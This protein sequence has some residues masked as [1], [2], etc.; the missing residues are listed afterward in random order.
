MIKNLPGTSYPINEKFTSAFSILRPALAATGGFT[1]SQVKELT[2]LE[3][4]TIQNWVK[5]GWVPSPEEKKYKELHI[6]R[7]LI[8]N[9]LR[10]ALKMEDIIHLLKFV[11]GD[12]NDRSDD[13]IDDSELYDRICLIIQSVECSGNFS[14]EFIMREI[15]DNISNYERKG[16]DAKQRLAAALQIMV[17]A[18]IATSFKTK[19]EMLISKI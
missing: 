13:I 10:G 4:T 5:R 1:L 15:E 7:I 12:L 6:A 17:T 3:S 2:A 9:L 16:A 8:I 11:N 18:C 19:S 14:D